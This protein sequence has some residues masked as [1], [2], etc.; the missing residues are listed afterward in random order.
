MDP[1]VHLCLQ[2]NTYTSIQ[3]LFEGDARFGIDPTSKDFKQT[4]GMK[5]ILSEQGKRRRRQKDMEEEGASPAV[6]T[7]DEMN[8]ATTTTKR[9]HGRGGSTINGGSSREPP[10][11]LKTVGYQQG[12]KKKGSSLSKLVQKFKK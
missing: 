9:S 10:L 7:N 5:V 6:A 3:Q 2:Y 11:P 4:E 1:H 12:E 8:G